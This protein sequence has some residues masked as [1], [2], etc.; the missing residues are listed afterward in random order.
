ML[1]AEPHATADR[2]HE[3]RLEAARQARQAP[4]VF[5]LTISQSGHE[6]ILLAHRPGREVSRSG[7]GH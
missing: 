3:L 5:D 2:K 6:R 1:A 4:L 7:S